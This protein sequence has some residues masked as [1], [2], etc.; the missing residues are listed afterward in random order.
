MLASVVSVE[1]QFVGLQQE[2]EELRQRFKPAHPTMQAPRW[3]DC[4]SAIH[5]RCIGQ[6]VENL[7]DTQQEVLK[8]ERDV[9]VNTALYTALLNTAQELRAAKAG[10][11]GN[12]RIIDSSVASAGPIETEKKQDFV[13]ATVLDC[14]PLLVI[15]VSRK[16]QSGVGGSG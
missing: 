6:K 2:R 15:F 8:L 10:T 14:F 12:V 7:P 13:I 3:Q 4:P 9:Q 1:S 16:L 11:V 5:A